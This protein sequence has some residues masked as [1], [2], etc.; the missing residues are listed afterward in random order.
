MCH[1]MCRGCC[2]HHTR[3]LF[4]C[5][6]ALACLAPALALSSLL[7]PARNPAVGEPPPRCCRGSIR[8]DQ[9][10][11][12]AGCLAAGCMLRWA[13]PAQARCVQERWAL[14]CTPDGHIGGTLSPRAACRGYRSSAR[15]SWQVAETLLPLDEHVPVCASVRCPYNVLHGQRKP[16]TVR[17]TQLF[18]SCR[19]SAEPGLWLPGALAH[20]CACDTP[21]LCSLG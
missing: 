5:C 16:R 11:H 17:S 19:H 8:Q 18:K 9:Q 13:I 3:C 2:T 20:L 10:R 1:G 14:L 7:S 15:S 21:H 4:A 6:R 12:E